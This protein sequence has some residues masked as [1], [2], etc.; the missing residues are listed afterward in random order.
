MPTDAVRR[1]GAALFDAFDTLRAL[2]AAAGLGVESV[3]GLAEML[4]RLLTFD[5]Y[6]AVIW[7]FHAANTPDKLALVQGEHRLTWKQANE[8]SN[9]LANSLSSL[10]VSPTSRVATMLHNSIEWFETVAAIQ[11]IGASVVFVSYRYTAAEVRFLL[12]NSGAS[13]LLFDGESAEVACR[14]WRESGRP[15]GCAVAVGEPPGGGFVA[16]ET[17]LARGSADEPAAELRRGGSRTF[18]YTSGTTGRPKGAVRDVSRAGFA[19]L[20]GLLRRVPLRRTDRH[21]VAAPL[22][23]ATGAGFALIHI[24]L[25]ATI[26]VPP[27]FEPLE[28]LRVVDRERITTSALVPTMLQALVELPAAQRRRYD[29]STLRILVTTGSPLSDALEK[30]IRTIFGEVL[31]DIYGST[32]VAHVTVATPADKRACPG[33]IGRPVPGVDVVLLDDE[34]KPVADGEVGELFARS[35]LAIEGYHGD[36]SATSG[37]RFGDYFSVGDL[38]VRDPRGFLKLVGRKTDMVISGGLNVYP[39]EIEA[40]LAAHPAIREAAVVGVPDEK[41]GERVVAFVVA[42]P[43]VTLPSDAALVRF[44]K[45]S[46]AGYK[47]PRRFERVDELPRNPTGK[48]LKKDLCARAA[49]G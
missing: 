39:A 34:R 37:S 5:L 12:E 26:F 49:G 2:Q 10:G 45:K 7:S 32:E 13:L 1:A 19:A 28:F 30:A 17:L 29:S 21:L 16:Y 42:N 8:R 11:K 43:G 9:R 48:I 44:C 14:A 41:W 18:Q 6:P 24:A 33:T 27:R 35:D 15:E 46:L 38:A 3:A 40:V 36:E 25:G 47:V 20:F 4:R 23:H 31:Y 22:Y